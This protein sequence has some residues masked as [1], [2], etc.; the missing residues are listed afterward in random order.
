MKKKASIAIM[1][2]LIAPVCLGFTAITVDVGNWYA[3]LSSVSDQASA[4]AQDVTR[5]KLYYPGLTTQ[6][7]QTIAERA[8]IDDG[9]M[10]G[11]TVTV[12]HGSNSV[13]V[14][15]SSPALLELPELGIRDHEIGRTASSHAVTTK[16]G[17]II[18]LSR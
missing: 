14:G 13:T 3:T 9:G 8:V 11:E 4:A 18:S 7:E 10:S 5:A 15:L 12:T 2:A 17:T 16:S 6:A 1:T